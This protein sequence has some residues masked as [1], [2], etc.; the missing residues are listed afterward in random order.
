[1]GTPLFA[2]GA[3]AFLVVFGAQQNALGQ[4]LNGDG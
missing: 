1:M 2:E 3:D 4:P